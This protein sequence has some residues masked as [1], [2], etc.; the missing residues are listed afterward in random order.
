MYKNTLRTDQ[1]TDGVRVT[2]SYLHIS[3]KFLKENIENCTLTLNFKNMALSDGRTDGQADG[4]TDGR[5]DRQTDALPYREA[6]M[7]L[8]IKIDGVTAEI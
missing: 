2:H 5:M 7:L 4:W 6:G 1:R 8:K 3:L